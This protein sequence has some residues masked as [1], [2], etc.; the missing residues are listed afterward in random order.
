MT[1]KPIKFGACGTVITAL[2]CFTPILVIVLSAAGAGV[3]VQYLDWVL[4]PALGVFL[5]LLGYGLYRLNSNRKA[6][7]NAGD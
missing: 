3:L 1:N 6:T 7:G 5:L 2:C 4:F